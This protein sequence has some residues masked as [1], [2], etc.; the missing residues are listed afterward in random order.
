MTKRD[1][2]IEKAQA[3]IDEQT[4]KIDGFRARAKGKVAAQKIEVH[5]H[6]DKMEAQLKMAKAHLAE[7]VC[8]A[9]NAWEDLTNRFDVL[10]D[11]LT[12]SVKKFFN[13]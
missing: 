3:K 6:I 9:E 1:A 4:A 13:K 5:E 7:I 11:E 2:Y 8:S 10:S 12:S